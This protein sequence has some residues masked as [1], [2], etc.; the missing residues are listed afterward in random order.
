MNCICTKHTYNHI[1]TYIWP[2]YNISPTWISWNKGISLTKPPFGV[3]SCEVAII[4]PDICIRTN[5][6]I[7]S[8]DYS[9]IPSH[10]D[11]DFPCWFARRAIINMKTSMNI[12][13][14]LGLNYG[15]SG[16]CRPKLETLTLVPWYSNDQ[17]PQTLKKCWSSLNFWE[18]TQTKSTLT[19]DTCFGS[20]HVCF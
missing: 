9:W 4:W 18:M 3:R 10:V 17:I 15:T 12:G 14:A 5:L 16:V 11:P 13:K 6:S 2:N 19:L 1:Y 7:L 8:N 20:H